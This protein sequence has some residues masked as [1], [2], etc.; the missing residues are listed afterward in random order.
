LNRG[1]AEARK[2]LDGMGVRPDNIAG[3]STET[4]NLIQPGL[5]DYGPSAVPS[6][7]RLTQL[8]AASPNAKPL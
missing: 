1:F 8:A 6:H 5:A 7:V 4:Y 2:I 3:I